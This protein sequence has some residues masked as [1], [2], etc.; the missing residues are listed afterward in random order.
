[1]IRQSHPWRR[2]LRRHRAQLVKIAAAALDEE[3]PDYKIERPILY[4]AIIMRRLIESRKITD[5]TRGRQFA[6]EAFASL[7][8]R[9]DVMARLTM[10]GHIEEEFDLQA[11]TAPAM[12][13]W[14]MASELLHS[15]FINWEVDEENRFVAIYV[16]SIRNLATR[17]LR[18][19]LASY[20]AVIDAILSDKVER[21]RTFF[22]ENRRLR[23]EID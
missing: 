7:P 14:N 18:I 9:A 4:S 16:A 10:Q 22:D 12:D 17:L 5:K 3:M 8:D 23:V 2:E 13:I 1:M 21:M 20:L 6:V 15:G 11:P 19:P